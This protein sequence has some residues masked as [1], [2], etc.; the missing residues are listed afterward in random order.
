MQ[1]DLALLDAHRDPLARPVDRPLAERVSERHHRAAAVTDE[2]V[3]VLVLAAQQLQARIAS[4]NGNTLD[5]VQS[6]ELV[7]DLIHA[8][9]T[10][11]R[12]SAP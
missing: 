6:F 7:E 3:V 5:A 8:G 9:A 4:P 11:T 10:H 2:V 1:H 12:S